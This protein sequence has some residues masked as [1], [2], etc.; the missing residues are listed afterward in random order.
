M[1]VIAFSATAAGAAADNLAIGIYILKELKES[2]KSIFFFFI[3][4]FF[5]YKFIALIIHL[6]YHIFI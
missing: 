5:Y 3:I 1:V 6:P 2:P 4:P